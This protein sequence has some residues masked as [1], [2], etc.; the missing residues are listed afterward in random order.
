M[1]V[2]R[3]GPTAGIGA[4]F[5]LLSACSVSS[6]EQPADTS[7]EVTLPTFAATGQPESYA[8]EQ[9]VDGVMVER[10]YWV[11][12]PEGVE[13]PLPT[14]F[15]LHG[16][17]GTS[18]DWRRPGNTID[19]QVQEGLFVAVYPDGHLNSWNLGAE[20]STAD[21]V[22]FLSDRVSELVASGVSDPGRVYVFGFSNG[23]G[24]AQ[25]LALSDAGF[26]GIASFASQMIEGQLPDQ[27]TPAISVLQFHGTDDGLIPY[28]GGSSP[29]G[30][31]FLPAEE[32]AQIWASHNGCEAKPVETT[33]SKELVR[34]QWSGC[35][36][37]VR[38]EHS[39]WVGGGHALPTEPDPFVIIWAF[40]DAVKP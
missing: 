25:R 1:R 24:M 2:I 30:H 37:G 22:T 5:G 23:A 40:F 3:R 39:R 19:R 8:V 16:N 35:E 36:D 27:E 6:E 11:Q 4:I 34:L 13:A 38:V 10:S 18:A 21:D 14:V 32:S 17:G 12:R 7:D 29:V 15:Y 33:I 26:A 28:D 20:D 31:S 9:E